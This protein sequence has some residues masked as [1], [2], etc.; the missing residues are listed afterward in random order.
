MKACMKNLG[1]CGTGQV[2][3]GV[4]PL[5]WAECIRCKGTGFVVG[6]P[7]EPAEIKM[8]SNLTVISNDQTFVLSDFAD[9][10]N[11]LMAHVMAKAGIFPSISQARKN[12][13]D[14]PLTTGTWIVTKKK[15]KIEVAK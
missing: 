3:G 9:V 5:R 4:N 14:K 11:P 10:R 8:H 2:F 13:W 15:I 6:A 1:C 12:G 7:R